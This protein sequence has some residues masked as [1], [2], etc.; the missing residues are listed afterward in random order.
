MSNH[1]PLGLVILIIAIYAAIFIHEVGHVIGAKLGKTPIKSIT[2]GSGKIIV[3]VIFQKISI[4]IGIFPG[5]GVRTTLSTDQ[6]FCSP[7]WSRLLLTLGSIAGNLC[8]AGL[9]YVLSDI[10]RYPFEYKGVYGPISGLIFLVKLASQG[11]HGVCQTFLIVNVIAASISCLPI[12]KIDM[13]NALYSIF[14]CY[15]TKA[16]PFYISLSRVMVTIVSF[17]FLISMIIDIAN[18]FCHFALNNNFL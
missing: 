11:M 12:I 15:F 13:G 18:L 16:I 1:I 3:K 8:I 2:F 7:L 9:F 17:A 6:Y 4:M 10:N 14:D 5:G